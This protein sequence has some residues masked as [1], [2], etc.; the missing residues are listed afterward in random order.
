M[1]KKHNRVEDAL[2]ELLA[3]ASVPRS[4]GD[5]SCLHLSDEGVWQPSRNR[6]GVNTFCFTICISTR[7]QV[8]TLC[9][10]GVYYDDE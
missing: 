1:V 8:T 10:V 2:R 4:V 6:D 5:A 3:L 9:N 7:Y